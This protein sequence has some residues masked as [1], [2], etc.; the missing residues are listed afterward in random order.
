MHVIP[1][2]GTKSRMGR[3]GTA[4]VHRSPR[5]LPGQ[6]V[7]ERTDKFSTVSAAQESSDPRLGKQIRKEEEVEQ[8]K[9]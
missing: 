8:R 2:K 4:A 5:K 7:N 9:G 1:R 6:L 3:A